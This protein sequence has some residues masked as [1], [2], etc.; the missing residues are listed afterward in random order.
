MLGGVQYPLLTYGDE[1]VLSTVHPI[2]PWASAGMVKGALAPP[3]ENQKFEKT[4]KKKEKT[5]IKRV[6]PVYMW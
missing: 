4:Y 5:R 3:P 1:M 2:Y 6:F